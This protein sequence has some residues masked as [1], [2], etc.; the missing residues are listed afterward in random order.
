MINFKYEFQSKAVLVW[1]SVHFS[2][3]MNPNDYIIKFK[4]QNRVGMARLNWDY[5]QQSV[6]NKFNLIMR[7]ITI[8]MLVFFNSNSNRKLD[9]NCT[10]Q[11]I[12]IKVQ[13]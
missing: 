11:S 9:K 6:I 10:V 8:I 13:L 4:F 12:S 2:Y 7:V 3:Y 5:M 1:G